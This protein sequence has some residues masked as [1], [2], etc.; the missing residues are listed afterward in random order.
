MSQR[1]A[2]SLVRPCRWGRYSVCRDV[3]PG[4][5]GRLVSMVQAN[6][7]LQPTASSLLSVATAELRAVRRTFIQSS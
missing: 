5:N 4:C 1:N 6:H 7:S 3:L 2:P